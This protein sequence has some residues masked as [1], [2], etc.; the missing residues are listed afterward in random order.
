VAELKINDSSTWRNITEVKVND[1]GTWRTIQDIKI[2][3]AGTWRTVWQYFAPP[4]P[5]TAYDV[6]SDDVPGNSTVST[7]TFNSDGTISAS[8]SPNDGGSTF[9]SS[10]WGAP[11]TTGIGSGYWVKLT[12]TSGTFTTNGASTFTNLASAISATKSGN[13]GTASVTFTIQIAT[14]SGGSNII[15]TSTGNLLRYTHT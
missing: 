5:F 1:A 6:W 7:I 8:F 14:D 11:T 3:D 4:S 13:S 2:N 12:A 15:L 9:G 10:N